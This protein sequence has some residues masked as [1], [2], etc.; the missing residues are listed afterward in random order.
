MVLTTERRG[1][2]ERTGPRRST[3]E[4]DESPLLL[5][6]LAL[7]LSRAISVRPSRATPCRCTTNSRR[8]P[9]PSLT[10]TLG[11]EWRFLSAT[12]AAARERFFSRGLEWRFLSGLWEGFLPEPTQLNSLLRASRFCD[13]SKISGRKG[14]FPGLDRPN[15]TRPKGEY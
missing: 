14:C 7:P 6:C 3:W 12:S 8:L 10:L 13:G 9:P 15:Q 2:E 1:K 4:M 5:P 11:M